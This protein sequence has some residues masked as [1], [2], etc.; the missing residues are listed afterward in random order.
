M[1]Y[2]YEYKEYVDLRETVLDLRN[3]PTITRDNVLI[4]IQPLLRYKVNNSARLAYETSDVINSV[5][6]IVQTSLRAIVGEMGLDDTLA[7]REEI[8]KQMMSKIE[9]VCNNWGITVLGLE[10][11]EISTTDDIQR[12]M[13]QMI[14]SE[15]TRRTMKVKADGRAEAMKLE[16]EGRCTAIKTNSQGE[17]ESEKIIALANSQ[18]KLMI[19]DSE[20]QSVKI[21]KEALAEYDVNPA[22]YLVALK[23]LETLQEI[24]SYAS[25]ATIY[26]P[27]ET[28]VIGDLST[29]SS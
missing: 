11:L 1:S 10:L 25:D 9:G 12:S 17:A 29:I 2:V 27:I 24:I 26:M 20:A 28:D 18:A 5:Q 6:K 7:S 3:Q 14:I 16:A 19:A 23:Y 22:Q 4:N 13:N 21:M 15:R 8:Q